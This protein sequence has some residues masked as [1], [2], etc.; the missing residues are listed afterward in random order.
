MRP[1][2]PIAAHFWPGGGEGQEALRDARGLREPRSGVALVADHGLFTTS[3]RASAR[4]ASAS[5]SSRS[6]G[7][8]DIREDD[9]VP[10]R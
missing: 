10:G 8:P 6:E 9:P 2:L 3:P 5:L 1:S 4:G 7:R